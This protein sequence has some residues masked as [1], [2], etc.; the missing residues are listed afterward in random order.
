MRV[1]AKIQARQWILNAIQN[2]SCI[3]DKETEHE[4]RKLVGRFQRDIK[5]LERARDLFL[6]VNADDPEIKAQALR[7]LTNW[8][9]PKARK[10][11]RKTRKENAEVV[12]LAREQRADANDRRIRFEHAISKHG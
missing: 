5:Q 2:H 11:H 10:R 12:R 3:P 7:E 9:Q 8:N 6:A 1:D 4:I